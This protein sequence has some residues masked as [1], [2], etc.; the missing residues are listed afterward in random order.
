M[1]FYHAGYR[2]WGSYGLSDVP[3]S[4]TQSLLEGS[5]DSG[6]FVAVSAFCNATL[7][8]TSLQELELCR[9]LLSSADRPTSF[10]AI[11]SAASGSQVRA[12]PNYTE[13]NC[14]WRSGADAGGGTL[15]HGSPPM[16]TQPSHY[17]SDVS[18][19]LLLVLTVV[20]AVA[21]LRLSRCRCHCPHL[22][23]AATHMP[24]RATATYTRSQATT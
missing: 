12:A 11:P 21:A 24:R 23:A 10:C 4:C 9:R 19:L 13:A 14:I 18:E 7:L 5:G 8:P 16:S 6:G 15:S 20:G 22:A 2:R 1:V 17:D 3:S